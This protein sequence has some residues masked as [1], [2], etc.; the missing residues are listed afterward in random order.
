[1]LATIPEFRDVDFS[2]LRLEL[3]D[4]EQ[5]G[6]VYNQ[7]STLLWLALLLSLLLHLSLLLFEFDSNQ[8]SPKPASTQTLHIDLLQALTKKPDAAHAVVTEK[9]VELQPVPEMVKE[10][11]ASPVAAKKMIVSE[12]LREIQPVTRLVIEPLSSQELA[13]IVNS[14]DAQPDYENAP[15][16]VE[17][18]FHPELRRKLIAASKE[19]R[20]KRVEDEDPSTGYIDPSGA[21]RVETSMGTCLSSPQNNKIGAPHNWY[22][23]LCKG[24]SESEEI[25]ERV[26]QSVNGKLSFED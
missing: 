2:H 16:I 14:H 25:M 22:V 19:R 6:L 20:K 3:A 7:R 4:P 11:I 26:E 15:P 21:V 9:I 5:V 23:S 12:Q 17:N 18:V 1:M 24:K 10:N 13:E 8:P